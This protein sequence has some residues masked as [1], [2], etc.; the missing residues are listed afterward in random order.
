MKT[1]IGLPV[2]P[3]VSIGPAVVY[4]KSERVLPVSSG[5]PAL[6]QAKFDAARETARE[7][8]GALDEKAKMELG[9]EKAAI[10]EVQM[11]MLEDLD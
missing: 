11:L 2:F 6:E 9:E 5:D 4:R 8:L 3:G 1:G 7:Q 10:V